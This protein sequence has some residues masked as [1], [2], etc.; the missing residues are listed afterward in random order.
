M[1]LEY[2]KVE[3]P[4][5]EQLQSLGWRYIDG[6]LLSDESDE[7]DSMRD[8]LLK[9]QLENAVK[10][11]NPWINDEN[12]RKIL[13]N[14]ALPQAATLMEANQTIW[15]SLVQYQSV[16]Q[17]LG[18]GRRGQTV[19]IIDFDHIENNEFVVVNQFK[20][21]GINQ[22]IIP[23][24]VLFVNGLPLAV[25]ECKSPYIT[26]PMEAGINQLLRYANRRTPH[27]DEGA[28]KLFW[29][30]QM[31][32][33]THRDKARVGTISSRMEHY[34]EWKDAYASASGLLAQGMPA[35][36]EEELQQAAEPE[37][38]Y[39]VGDN[40]QEVLIAGLFNRYNF[41][42]IIRNFTVFEPIDGKVIKKIARYQQFRAVHKTIERIKT[43]RNRK[44][45]G[46]VVW[47]TQG[48]GKSL[49]MVM[50]AVKM[51]RD[52]ELKDYKLVFMTDRTQLDTQLTATFERAQGETVYHAKSVSHLKELLQKDSSD[53]ITAMMQKLQE[54]ED[55]DFPE[56]N[57]SEKIVVLADEA[58]RTQ[59]GALGVALNTALP[60][61][62]KV[63]FTGTPLIASQK[64][65]NEFGSY[66]D[67]YTIEQAVADGATVQILYEGREA[68]TKV[69]GDS[70]DQL[71]DAYF[72]DRNDDEK[73]AIKKKYGTLAA[74]LEA[75]QRI[76]WI[77]IDL[78]QHY[79]EHIQPNGFKAMIVTASRQAAIL[80][81]EALDELDGP[82]SEVII[83]GNHNDSE[84]FNRYTDSNKQ[85]VAIEAYKKP[86]KESPISIL[87][88]KD[89]LLT[90][91]DAPICQVM[92]LDRKLTEHNLLQAIARVNR[93]YAGKSRGFIVDY[94]GLSDYL[95]EALEMF[96]SEDVA[97]AL[98]DLK[99]EIPKLKQMHTRVMGH[100]KGIDQSD[101][102]A[103]ILH[104]EDEARRQQFEIDFKKFAKQMDIIMPDAAAKP[105]LSD[106]VFLGKVNQGARNLYRDEQLDIA[107]CGEKVRKLIDE[108][109]R[110]IGVDVKIPPIDLLAAN[111]KEKLKE[112]KSSRA[113]ASE[114]EN[115]IKHHISVNLQEDE[116][117][118]KK[119]SE[120][121]K[122]IVDKHREHWDDL[123]QLLL[124]FRDTIEVNHKKEAEDIGLSQVEYA[125]Y[126][127]LVAE[128]TRITGNES[129]DEA[130]HDEV[131]QVTKDLVDMLNEATAIVDFFSKQN[132]ISAV[133]KRIKRRVIETSFDDA[134]LRTAVMDRFME[135]A[136][137]KFSGR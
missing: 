16:E 1:S 65:N 111:F 22:N 27:E 133:K 49:T 118:Y 74:V 109:L 83:S 35:N 55:F 110:A 54:E 112:H 97:G 129:I 66:I 7:R 79:R 53:L 25:I 92:Y 34:L 26:N 6:R 37:G 33:S 84:F 63:A 127:I 76:R 103:C 12:L 105:F 18:K 8:I 98:K 119:L 64:T 134:D 93:T 89:M 82:A 69:T 14:I 39:Q 10:R 117:Y 15:E 47:H 113:R 78:L 31:M 68:K 94:Y 51:R 123:V 108:H 71:F 4:A 126:N 67:T 23:D 20:V 58:H 86:L 36:D 77:C 132:E 43:G 70:L 17:D 45:R 3:L 99:D 102:D 136:K 107:G 81:K 24:I 9:S 75:P 59:Y 104:L 52:P 30:N 88:V 85:K 11:L 38:A 56:L 137:V 115:A 57:T 100:F 2:E 130:T 60:N 80:Y 73:F 48:S 19:K 72:H 116:E 128:I 95:T 91:F 96:S 101:L 46:G 40:S 62:P 135:L 5:I 125:F 44:E 131:I 28:E 42:D 32:V 124:E 120:R 106:L 13:R 114:I 21:E 90:G 122:A 50:L 121:L 87:V 29:Y 41:L 61:A